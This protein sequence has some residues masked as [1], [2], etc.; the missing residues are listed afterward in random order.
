MDGFKYVSSDEITE[1]NLKQPVNFFWESS[2]K[3]LLYELDEA[4]VYSCD[5]TDLLEN[6][7]ELPEDLYVFDDTFSWAMVRSHYYVENKC[8]RILNV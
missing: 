5:F 6:M 8:W 1:L 3:I 4:Y 2:A 7:E